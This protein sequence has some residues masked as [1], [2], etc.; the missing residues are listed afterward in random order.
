MDY[1]TRKIARITCQLPF[2]LQNTWWFMSD[3]V[4]LRL[5]MYHAPMQISWLKQLKS[6]THAT[7]PFMLSIPWIG[8]LI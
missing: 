3:L 8:G 7:V 1:L 6:H 5:Y 4:S 2:K